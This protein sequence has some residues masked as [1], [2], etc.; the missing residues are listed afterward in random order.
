MMYFNDTNIWYQGERQ[1]PRK[2]E[3]PVVIP[4]P[5]G[6]TATCCDNDGDWY[7]LTLTEIFEDDSEGEDT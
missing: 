1:P 7:T 4:N 6:I 5:D 3:L 2:V